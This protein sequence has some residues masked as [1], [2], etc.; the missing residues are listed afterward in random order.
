[1]N[2]RQSSKSNKSDGE[3]QEVI[4]GSTI[5]EG[6]GIDCVEVTEKGS[7]E[8]P[9]SAIDQAQRKL[10]MSYMSVVEKEGI[11]KI[12]ETLEFQKEK[13]SLHEDRIILLER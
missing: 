5:Q 6:E 13:R 10:E 8:R 1:M 3:K 11:E 9:S 7:Y 12:N 2:N 4:R